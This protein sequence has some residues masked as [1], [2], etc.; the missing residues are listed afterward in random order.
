MTF[1]YGSETPEGLVDT[2][3]P[4]AYFS[5]TSSYRSKVR[6][7]PAW[8]IIPNAEVLQVYNGDD[9][10]RVVYR[11][12]VMGAQSEKTEGAVLSAHHVIE[13]IAHP[14]RVPML[15]KTTGT[16]LRRRARRITGAD[17]N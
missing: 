3:S 16:T 14:D 13:N 5:F 15:R 17:V 10:V 4:R 1:Y 7:T 8:R 11:G 2:P 9:G 6:Q 12:R